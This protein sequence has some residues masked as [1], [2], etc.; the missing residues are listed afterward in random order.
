VDGFFG[1]GLPACGLPH[2]ATGHP[3]LFG[4][5]G[6]TTAFRPKV[7]DR[8]VMA[9]ARRLTDRDRLILKMI[10]RHRV[11][12]TDQLCEMY[13]DNINTAQHR[14]TTLHGLRL[15]ERFQPIDRRFATQPYHYVLGQLGAMVVVAEQDRDPDDTHWQL[16]KSLAIGHSQRLAH[17]VGTNGLFSA[18]E[19]EGRRS[20]DA[21]LL[22]WWSERYRVSSFKK[23]VRPD[24]LGM[25]E[26]GSS[27]VTFCLEYH[28]STE[29][30]DR[31]AKKLKGYEDLQVTT[32]QPYW[33]L[34][35]FRHPRREA[36]AWRVLADATVPVA[37]AVLGPTQRPHEA[38]WAPIG[39]G[40]SRIR[41]AGLAGVTPPPE[42]HRRISESEDWRLHMAEN[43]RLSYGDQ[44]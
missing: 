22:L 3:R 8:L 17:L 37:I 26:E 32:G 30:L 29:T 40:A 35:S 31:L 34:F 11:L 23:N 43:H 20:A 13:F 10:Y 36:G 38:I 18:L 42:S 27:R 28:R 39:H 14:L 21:S 33:I 5:V 19:A 15:V 24:G 2:P 1:G 16:E 9:A 41:L 7:D 25:W 4:M 44:I 12:T 6:M